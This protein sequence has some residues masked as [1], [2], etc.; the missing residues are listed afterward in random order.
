[1]DVVFL[2][3]SQEKKAACLS[4]FDLNCPEY[5]APNERSDYEDFLNS[6][7]D[8]YELCERD[9]ELVGAFGVSRGGSGTAGLEWIML[10]PS[11]QG[12]GLG[13]AIMQRVIEQARRLGT[14]KL[15]IATSHKA[16]EFFEKMGA[17]AVSEVENGWGPGMHRIDME[18]VI[19]R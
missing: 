6:I 10:N 15:L 3:Y 5:F 11:A 7:P 2:K 9:G 4:L 8:D 18:L 17:V 12:G 1:M 19:D 16:H 14:G 13:T